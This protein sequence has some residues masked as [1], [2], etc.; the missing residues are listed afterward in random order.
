MVTE[1][2]T[3]QYGWGEGA[4]ILRLAGYKQS[5]ERSEQTQ[6]PLSNK[7]TATIGSRSNTI[8]EPLETVGLQKLPIGDANPQV[9]P[10]S[11]NRQRRTLQS[12]TESLM[13]SIE[14]ASPNIALEKKQ[15]AND[16]IAKYR[17]GTITQVDITFNYPT[18]TKDLLN[19]TMPFDVAKTA[20]EA[21]D[22]R[23]G[24]RRDTWASDGS[25][26]QRP[27]RYNKTSTGAY[28]FPTYGQNITSQLNQLAGYIRRSLPG[29]RVI[30]HPI[31]VLNTDI[32][33]S[34]RIRGF[35]LPPQ[36]RR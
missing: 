30:V 34:I 26:A 6:A 29:V 19:T 33:L 11:I 24:E 36:R 9:K 5:Y 8:V 31:R 28:T 25:A 1:T 7:P 12:R 15:F 14:I 16:A 3:Y 10:I 32:S 2:I 17:S 35:N 4:D 21:Y 13:Q 20:A 23:T 18:I 27:I 22:K